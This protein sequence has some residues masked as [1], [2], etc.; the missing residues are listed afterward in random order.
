MFVNLTLNPLKKRSTGAV[1]DPPIWIVPNK[2]LS[3]SLSLSLSQA[4]LN[5]RETLLGN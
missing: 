5:E 4:R 3:L 2:A 1:L